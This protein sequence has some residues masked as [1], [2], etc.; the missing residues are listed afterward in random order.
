[1]GGTLI[2]EVIET[3]KKMGL[4]EFGTAMER[5]IEKTAKVSLDGYV[6]IFYNIISAELVG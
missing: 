1:M 5:T 3:E 6:N 2:H 4:A